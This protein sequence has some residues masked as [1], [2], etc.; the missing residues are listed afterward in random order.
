MTLLSV[1]HRKQQQ[2]ADCLAACAAMVLEYLQIPVRYERLLR[3]LQVE[4]FGSFF[5]NLHRLESLGVSVLIE[6]GDFNALRQH[7]E[8]GLPALV[9]VF[10][11]ELPNWDISTHHVVTVVGLDEN[12][13]YVNDPYF[14]ER[15][16]VPLEEFR[17]AWLAK[18]SL[19]A[20]IALNE[21]E[22]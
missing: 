13:I 8:S 20:V 6:A 15:Q 18:E 17:L 12:M 7:L 16:E 9:M 22:S 14:D 4:E 19:Y 3:L 10:T 11:G 1:P 21:I 5:R 2:Q